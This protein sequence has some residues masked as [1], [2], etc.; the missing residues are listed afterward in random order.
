[1]ASVI[2]REIW[3]GFSTWRASPWRSTPMRTQQPF[4]PA[5]ASLH[6]AFFGS[7]A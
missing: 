5:R 1:M 2:G 7:R 4:A 6:D 3:L